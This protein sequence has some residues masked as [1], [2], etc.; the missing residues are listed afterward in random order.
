LGG[1]A[2][3]GGIGERSARLAEGKKK[4]NNGKKKKKA[5]KDCNEN[6]CDGKCVD[7]LTDR[8]NCGAC[9]NFCVLGQYCT[10][11]KCMPCD[12][13][14]SVCPVGDADYCA[15]LQT[16]NQNCG[17]CGTVCK[18]DPKNNPQ[19]DLICLAGACVCT[20][21][22]CPS[23]RCCPAGFLC[24]RDD[25]CCP[26]GGDYCGSGDCCPRGFVCGGDCGDPCCPR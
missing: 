8:N 15:N 20:G 10:G 26:E 5:C 17:S 18:K 1:L 19:R 11:G 21:T 24:N 23:G 22:F 2:L 7:R 25:G 6:C 13:P 14:K 9:G 4:K 16:D 3:G 12:S